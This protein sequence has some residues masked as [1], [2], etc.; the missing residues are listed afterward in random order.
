MDDMQNTTADRAATAEPAVPAQP[1]TS[2]ARSVVP[3]IS[4]Q[5]LR[6]AVL[7]EIRRRITEGQYPQGARLFEDQIA[8]ELDVA[9]GGDA[10]VSGF[11]ADGALVCS[12]GGGG[13]QDEGGEQCF[14][15][16]CA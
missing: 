11:A 6:H 2:G 12:Q 7:T 1:P 14:H 5:P 15:G 9:G 13:E 3:A 8:A 16:D 4:H 10:G